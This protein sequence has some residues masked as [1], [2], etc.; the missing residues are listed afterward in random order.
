MRPPTGLGAGTYEGTDTGAPTRGA[1]R[2]VSGGD[3]PVTR[4]KRI[5]VAIEN[6]APRFVANGVDFNDFQRV[7]EPLKRWDDW[8]AAW[9]AA[10][11]EHARLA[12]EAEAEG[13]YVSAG[14]HYVQAAMLYHFGKF[15]FFHRP[16]EHR[17]A[18]EE[19]VRLYGCGLPY[20]AFPGERVEIPYEGA[21]RIPGILRKP[22]HDPRPPVVILVPGLDSVKEEMHFYG[23]DFLRRGMAVLAIDGPGQGEMEFDHAM[24]HDYEVPIGRVIDYLATRR[25]LDASRIGLMGVSLGGYYGIRAATFEDRLRAVIALA[26]GYR[27]ADYFDRVPILTREAFIHRLHTKTPEEARKRL[28][29]FDL[30]GVVGRLRSPVLVIMGRQDRLFPAEDTEQMVRDANGRAELLMYEEGNHVCNNIPYK[31]RPRQADWMQR[32]LGL[33]A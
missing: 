23:D 4:E 3:E 10:G 14:Q 20:Y 17:P 11:A 8:C 28:E 32:R 19:V 18:H 25:D 30:E 29:A 33:A 21:D 16:E 5:Q 26:I 22:W 13:F 7:T 27:L 9:S 1:T 6:W 31:Y 12:G 15:M 2:G 24:R